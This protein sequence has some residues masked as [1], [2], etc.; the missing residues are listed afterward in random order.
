MEVPGPGIE[1]EPQLYLCHSCSNTGS[2]NPL[3]WGLNSCLLHEVSC[4]SYLLNPLHYSG[5]SHLNFI[6]I[7]S[8][9]RCFNLVVFEILEV[10]AGNPVVFEILEVS[11][12]NPVVFEILE[13]DMILSVLGV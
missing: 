2:F 12:G 5:N 11:A 8:R 4:C 6:L 7:Y 13:V 9:F 10:S 1:S 3:G